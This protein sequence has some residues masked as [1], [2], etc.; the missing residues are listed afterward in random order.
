[1]LKK[2]I[3]LHIYPKLALWILLG[4]I[5]F[6]IVGTL[7]HELG[8]INMAKAFGYKTHLGYGYMNYYDS[9][10]SIEFDTITARNQEAIA[11]NRDFP[12]KE[13][14]DTLV[15]K[16]KISSFLITLGG[17]LQ[18]IISGT[19]GFAFLCSWR[20]RIR[21][22]GMKLKDWIFVFISLFWLRQLANPLTGLMRS[23][24]KG[25]FNPFGGHSDELVLARYLGWWE[26][27]ISLPLALIALGIAI[28]V[29]FK[30]LP[31]PVRFTFI[32]AG[33]IGGVLGY[34]IWLVWVGPVLMP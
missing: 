11:S 21:E 25:G 33:F 2:Y 18:T 4:F 34:M 13:H 12:E 32:S 22:Y 3:S 29:I 9:P 24:A 30:I 26:G 28:Y 31:K 5:G 10:L 1:M 16:L 23:I 8:H 27:S 6:T 19:V 15:E 20:R 7:T 17:P 14:L